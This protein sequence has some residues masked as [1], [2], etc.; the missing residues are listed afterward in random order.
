[1]KQLSKIYKYLFLAF[2]AVL[3]FSYFPLIHFGANDSMNF[4][5]S[6]PLIHLVIF[7]IVAIVLIISEKKLK[8]LV[9]YKLWLLYPVFVTASIVWSLNSV[10]GILTSGIMWALY[11]AG[12]SVVVF[13]KT[14]LKNTFGVLKKVI[15]TSAGVA[16]LWC[17]VQCVLDLCG[18]GRDVS[19][20]CV[21]CTKEMFGFPHPNGFAIEPQFMG[22]LLIAPA[23]LAASDTIL[24][25]RPR[26]A[27]PSPRAAGANSR[28]AALRNAASLKYGYHLLLT[29]LFA[30]GVFLTFSRG[31]IYAF[32][33]GLILLIGYRIVKDKNARALVLLPIM[34]FSF[35]LSL[36]TQGMM[37]ASSGLGETYNS[38]VAKVLNHLSLGVI[39]L[40]TK[41]EEPKTEETNKEEVVEEKN[42]PVFDGY[43]AESTETRVK[44]TNAG[45]DIWKKNFNTLAVGVGVG[46]AGQALYNNHYA[47][48]P[49]EIVQNEYVSVLLE[50][51]VIGF[52]LFIFTLGMAFYVVW[53]KTDAKFVIVIMAAYGITLFFF[54]GFPNALHIYLLPVMLAATYKLPST[55]KAP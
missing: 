10:R 53:K 36:N 25:L 41:N 5:L 42:E 30:F 37:A 6:L 34:L 23:L 2:P 49:K 39:D 29:I 18:V 22:N 44:W 33:V 45:I 35:L 27:G 54:S 31:A 24:H 47:G 8:Y 14:F 12:F 9:K 26:P 38:G 21:G 11:I 50:A 48:A 55:K 17:V 32:V 19:L 16:I 43:V 7:D 51:G 3:Y 52:A 13:R 1:M 15:Y 28:A 20:L 40:R 4:E 46:G